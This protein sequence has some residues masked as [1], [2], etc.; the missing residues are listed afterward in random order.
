ME[1]SDDGDKTDKKR[2]KETANVF[3]M[4]ALLSLLGQTEHEATQSKK[5]KAIF[6]VRMGRPKHT[7]VFHAFSG[8]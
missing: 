7:V 6:T 5:K 1:K 3:I 2:E 4:Q 8:L